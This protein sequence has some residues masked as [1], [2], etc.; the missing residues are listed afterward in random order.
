MKLLLHLPECLLHSSTIE[1]NGQRDVAHCA[2]HGSF[3]NLAQNFHGRYVQFLH[4]RIPM[5]PMVD[6]DGQR[7]VT[8]CAQHGFLGNLAQNFHSSYVY[9]FIFVLQ[10][11]WMTD[12]T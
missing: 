4:I 3:G 9:F 11:E 5:S 2:R 1:I 12:V 8:H 10:V 7:N 6:L